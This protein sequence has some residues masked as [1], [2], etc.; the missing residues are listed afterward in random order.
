LGCKTSSS[1]IGRK[2]RKSSNPT[3]F[4]QEELKAA[5]ALLTDHCNP[6]MRHLH[7]RH[8]QNRICKTRKARKGKPHGRSTALTTW[9]KIRGK[10]L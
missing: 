3:K 4:D 6:H 10:E 1:L 9:Q 7:L 5:L 8:L 2:K